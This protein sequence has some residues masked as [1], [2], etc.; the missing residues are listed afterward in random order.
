MYRKP[1][2]VI[3]ESASGMHQRVQAWEASAG[4]ATEGPV[5]FIADAVQLADAN[6]V[7]VQAMRTVIDALNPGVIFV[8]TQARATVGVEENS[9]RDMGKFV[10]ALERLREPTG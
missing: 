5:K 1:L 8:D 7:D 2:Y 9:S 6:H 4:I 10:D 3:A